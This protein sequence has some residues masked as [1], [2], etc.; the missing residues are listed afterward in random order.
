MVLPRSVHF[1]DLEGGE[2]KKILVFS[3]LGRTITF[4]K[5]EISIVRWKLREQHT[6]QML[7]QLSIQGWKQIISETLHSVQNSRL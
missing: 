3:L 7:L 2:R 6:N 1:N 4:L 5:L